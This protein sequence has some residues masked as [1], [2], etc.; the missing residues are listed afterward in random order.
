LPRRLW[1]YGKGGVDHDFDNDGIWE[2]FGAMSSDF[3]PSARI[4]EKIALAYDG[5]D[6]VIGIFDH[7]SD[8]DM[9]PPDGRTP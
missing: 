6:I 3:M 1:D 9:L 7:F 5:Q 8:F 2:L 4:T